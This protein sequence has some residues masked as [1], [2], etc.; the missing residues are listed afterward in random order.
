MR[1]RA[2]LAPSGLPERKRARAAGG[3][4][5][6]RITARDRARPHAVSTNEENMTRR[7]GNFKA[8]VLQELVA[9]ASRLA[10][11]AANLAES[12]NDAD[13]EELIREDDAA[14]IAKRPVRALRDARRAGELKMYGKQRSRTV[15]RGDLDAWI[16]ASRVKP[17]AGVDDADI[18]RRMARLQRT[19]RSA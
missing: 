12:A 15:R 7:T 16:E 2:K 5:P 10:S 18:E 1:H 17:S 6:S 3:R 19:R 8:G 13:P 9:I 4:R 14:R 11:V